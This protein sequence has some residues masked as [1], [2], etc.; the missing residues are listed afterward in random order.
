MPAGARCPI[1]E[2]PGPVGYDAEDSVVRLGL[3]ALATDLTTER[4]FARLVPRDRAALHVSRVAY[5]N[6]TTPDN[7]RRMAPRLSE[8]AALLVPGVRLAAICYACTSASVAIGEDAVEAAIQLGQPGVPVVTPTR[9]AC[10]AFEALGVRRIALLTPYLP[11]TTRPMADYFARTGLEVAGARCLSLADDR[12]MA[13]IGRGTIITEAL[14]VD[15]E[16]AEALFLSCTAMPSLDAVAEIEY[17]VGKPVVSSNQAS[18]WAMLAF[19][20]LPAA[21]T[22]YGRL[23]RC[24][25]PESARHAA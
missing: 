17:R 16:E 22:G 8:A 9:A 24:A 23:F 5:E 7:L 1:V 10:W 3:V 15:C 12:E 14:R 25:L 11:E 21:E 20:G 19:A 6:P 2:S 4:D 18:I 13:R